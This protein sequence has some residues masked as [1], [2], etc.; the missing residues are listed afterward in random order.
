MNHPL[1]DSTQKTLQEW[2]RDHPERRIAGVC[3]TIA[4]QLEL[5]LPIVRSGFVIAALIPG[6]QGIGL[7][8]YGAVWALTPPAPG[9]P[10]LLDR[11]S[12]AIGEFVGSRSDDFDEVDDEVEFENDSRFR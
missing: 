8:L 2:H 10:T 12:A 7:T 5:P 6:L 4:H 11:V 1:P 3:T 9:E